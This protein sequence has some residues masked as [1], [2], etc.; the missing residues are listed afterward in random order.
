MI[1]GAVTL[2]KSTSLGRRR[3]RSFLWQLL[4]EELRWHPYLSL[5]KHSY[6]HILTCIYILTLHIRTYTLTLHTHLHT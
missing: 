2:A 5:S 6:A 4:V 1:G 3:N